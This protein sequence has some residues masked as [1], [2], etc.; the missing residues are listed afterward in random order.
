MRLGPVAWRW[1]PAGSGDIGEIIGEVGGRRRYDQPGPVGSHGGSLVTPVPVTR[2]S[3]LL[4]LCL[5]PAGPEPADPAARP[6]QWCGRL[7]G[8]GRVGVLRSRPRG[9]D[10]RGGDLF[11]PPPLVELAV[12]MSACKSARSPPA[13]PF[14]AQGRSRVRRAE[15]AVVRQLWGVAARRLWGLPRRSTQ[16]RRAVRQPAPGGDLHLGPR[17][18]VD[19]GL[20]HP[21]PGLG[22]RSRRSCRG[23]GAWADRC[24]SPRPATGLH[25]PVGGLY[26]A[27]G[28]HHRR[29]SPAPHCASRAE[30][31]RAETAA[32]TAS[33]GSPTATPGGPGPRCA[34]RSTRAVPRLPGFVLLS[35]EARR[36]FNAPRPGAGAPEPGPQR[37]LHRPPLRRR[38]CA[39]PGSLRWSPSVGRRGRSPRPTGRSGAGRGSGGL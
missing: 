15:P 36:S 10:P 2:V 9:P 1:R 38:R 37:A 16:R 30:E 28:R 18:G 27:G 12:P 24:S 23:P 25:R 3:R 14:S 19:G 39:A 34:S 29:W 31:H 21:R 4:L 35:A 22:L 26:D 33:P 6:G 8:D 32:V 17:V 20:H 13:H 5:S 7:R 11:S